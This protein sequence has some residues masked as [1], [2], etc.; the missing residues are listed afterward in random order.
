EGISI[1]LQDVTERKQAADAMHRLNQELDERVKAR[2]TQLASS[3]K[4]AEAARQKAEAANRSKS[5]FLANMSHELRTPLNAIIGYSE[6]LEEDAENIGQDDFV[7]DLQKIRGSGK[8]LLRLINDVLDLSKI[9]AGRMELTPETFEIRPMLKDV[10]STLQP[11]AEKQGNSVSIECSAHIGMMHADQTKVRQSLFNLL[12]NANKFTQRGQIKLTVTAQRHQNHLP[13][14]RFE[15][16]DT[17]IGMTPDQL[18]KVFQAFTQADASTTRKYGGTG[19]GLTITDRF[20][21]MMGGEVTVTSQYGQGTTFTID[22]PQGVDAAPPNSP[23]AVAKTSSP[24]QTRAISREYFGTVL[25]IDDD[26]DAREI[27]QRALVNAGYQVVCAERGQKGLQL[28]MELQPDVITLDVLMPEMDGWSVLTALKAN[29]AVAHIPVI[30]LTMADD[31]TLGYTLGAA[32]YLTKPID[33]NR[34]TATLE[35]YRSG[36]TTPWVLVVED[37]PHSREMMTRLLIR[38]GWNV[39]EADNGRRALEL[40]SDS[41]FGL[42][43]LDL[44][45]PGMDGFEFLHQMRQRP[46]WRT[47]P[48]VVVTAKDLTAAEHRQLGDAVQSFYQKGSLDQQQLLAEIEEFV[49]MANSA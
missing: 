7:P 47:I 40:L 21:R 49:S 12:S 27:L 25:V 5:E 45:M 41:P 6:M 13:W 44:M 35:K 3:M 16:S 28:A 18:Q 38:A 48:V 8:H 14:L 42:I 23:L 11:L 24:A 43:L 9:E 46:E 4:I 2:T 29:P 17:G 26:I 33:P 32:D 37:E 22:L 1:F 10:V 30:L 39:R 34:L 36:Q 15:I 31:Q 19:L 20:V